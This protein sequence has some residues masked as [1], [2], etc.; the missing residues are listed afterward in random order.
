M[1]KRL[2]YITLS[3]LVTAGAGTFIYAQNSY[4][5]NTSN[6]YV[7]QPG[8]QTSYNINQNTAG[9][10]NA[11]NQYQNQPPYRSTS[12]SNSNFG[13][14]GL[15]S[16]MRDS[17]SADNLTKYLP[18]NGTAFSPNT[19]NPYNSGIPVGTSFQRTLSQQAF[20]NQVDS[21][22]STSAQ[23]QQNNLQLMQIQDQL[24]NLYLQANSQNG[25][26]SEEIANRLASISQ[27]LN[28]L[29]Q[30]MEKDNFN[31]ST[32]SS[33]D[34]QR[35]MNR[36]GGNN[37][38]STSE[39]YSGINDN[40]SSR[41][42]SS[43]T[44]MNQY[45]SGINS[46]SARMEQPQ[47]H[48]NSMTNTAPRQTSYDSLD[49]IKQK[50]DDLSRSI[51]IEIQT[52]QNN[53][54]QHEPSNDSA[55][56]PGQNTN[57]QSYSKSQFNNYFKTAQEQLKSGNYYAAADSFMLASIYEPEN[58]LCYAGQGNALFAAGQYINS[59]LYIIRAIELN[60]DYIQVDVDLAA[61]SGGRD[62]V[63]SRI[64]ELEQ[65]LKKA[66]ATGLQFLLAYAYYRTGRLPEARQI[67]NV[68][69]QETPQSR[70]A[71][72]LKIVIDTKV[73]NSRQ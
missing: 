42:L 7:T 9:N 3:L 21:V 5:Q 55:S 53:A 45:Q 64:S 67:I 52:P 25:S 40:P 63:A 28:T 71:L 20:P 73:N 12:G 37:V 62:I 23:N 16:F 1:K 54:M 58:P 47:Y 22:S 70:A 11:G 46:A 24:N 32:V 65:L 69:Y 50:L 59:A 19:A 33:N 56:T 66:P 60:P 72:A 36:S 8:N 44:N 39:L 13:T 26:N 17:A 4:N 51:D 10:S 30:K 18:Q 61:I 38:T 43:N 41:H 15:S 68:L 34:M 49:Q 2:F 31:N 14:A 6:Q 29:Q 27:Q 57:F 48:A 35:Y